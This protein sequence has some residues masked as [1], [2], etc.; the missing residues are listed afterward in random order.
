MA[1]R[2]LYSPASALLTRVHRPGPLDRVEGELFVTVF[3]FLFLVYDI[4]LTT[5][6]EAK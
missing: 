2:V 1:W 3:C 5:T 6:T 4:D